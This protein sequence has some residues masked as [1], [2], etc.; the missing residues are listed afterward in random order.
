MKSRRVFLVSSASVVLLL[1]LL[2]AFVLKRP[3]PEV[4]GPIEPEDIREIEQLV[5]SVRW[6]LLQSSI[7][8]LDMSRFWATVPSVAGSSA[9]R[10]F[11]DDPSGHVNQAVVDLTN[12]F[13]S[14]ETWE[15]RFVRGPKGWQP[16][17]IV[18]H[19]K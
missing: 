12:R 17:P 1:L 14:K 10:I 4:Y 18:A 16:L 15:Y 13:D 6:R 2:V 8:K 11:T 3:S 19:T 9:S 7:V 5:L